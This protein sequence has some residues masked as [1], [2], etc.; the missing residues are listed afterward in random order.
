M[1]GFIYI[2]WKT[3]DINIYDNV[4]LIKARC[5]TFVGARSPNRY[6]L[7]NLTHRC[8]FSGVPRLLGAINISSN[9][10][11]N[12]MNVYDEYAHGIRHDSPPTGLGIIGFVFP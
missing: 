9:Q 6:G 1:K 4:S 7:G 12:G 2:S 8:Q 5:W 10:E 3:L 11:I